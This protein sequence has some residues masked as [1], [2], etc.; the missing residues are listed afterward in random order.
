MRITKRKMVDGLT[1]DQNKD[2]LTL[3]LEGYTAMDA[4]AI[5]I[6]PK[7]SVRAPTM[8]E[9]KEYNRNKDLLREY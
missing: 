9:L 4:I 2:A 3:M 6:S 7:V 1:K 8:A 5:V